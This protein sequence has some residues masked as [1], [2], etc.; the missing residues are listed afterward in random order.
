MT[1]QNPDKNHLS[2]IKTWLKAEDEKTGQGF[3]GNWDVIEKAY[4][5]DK[6][7]VLVRDSKPLAFLIYRIEE[8]TA[9]IDI[10]EVQPKY[11]EHG[12]GRLIV[13]DFIKI[14]TESGALAIDLYCSPEDSMRFW[15]SVGFE[16]FPKMPRK[17][18]KIWMYKPI[19]ETASIIELASEEEV[20]ELQQSTSRGSKTLTWLVER[21]EGTDMLMKPVIFPVDEDWQLCWRKGSE[22]FFN[23]SIRDFIESDI[24]FGDFLIIRELKTH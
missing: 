23:R 14:A 13:D 22:V 21:N 2:R 24:Y 11:R 7:L 5:N 9:S 15:K 6:M 8:L 20:L 3:Y 12:F 19:V 1:I 10:M 16:K 17:K 18:S 4:Q